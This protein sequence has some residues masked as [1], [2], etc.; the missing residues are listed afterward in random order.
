[1]KKIYGT[2]NSVSFE[3]I[4]EAIQ[5]DYADDDILIIDNI[6]PF[7]GDSL[8]LDVILFLTCIK[9]KLQMR[10]KSQTFTLRP[11]EVFCCAPNTTIDDCMISPDCET[12]I[13]CISPRIA[14]SIF[15]TDKKIWNHYFRLSR[16]PVVKIS[17]EGLQLFEHYYRLLRYRI[18]LTQRSYNKKTM[19]SLIS[20]LLHDLL[21]ELESPSARET[22]GGAL[23][24]QGDILFKRFIELLSKSEPKKR[25]VSYYAERLY[26]TPKYMSTTVKKISGKTALEWINE[27]VIEDIKRQLAFSSKSIKEIADYLMF[28]SISFFGKYVKKHLGV[29]PKEFRR[30]LG[31]E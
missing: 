17:E 16:N 6:H 3:D 8:T 12:I 25:S 1:M 14:Q 13:L 9:G 29:S 20:A 23:I 22:D 5:T 10:I 18:K 11:R 27:Y 31:K 19:V 26:I 15:H 30:Q 24:S 7:V 21:A 2:N 4:Q 28:P